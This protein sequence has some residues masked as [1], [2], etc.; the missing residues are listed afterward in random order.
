MEEIK[1]KAITLSD[2]LK[3]D[4]PQLDGTMGSLNELEKLIAALG[5]KLTTELM[6]KFGAY[7]GEVI[8]DEIPDADWVN[9]DNAKDI[10]G[11]LEYGKDIDLLLRHKNQCVF[12]LVKVTKFFHNGSTDSIAA[13]GPVAAIT[14]NGGVKK[15]KNNKL[16]DPSSFSESELVNIE[17]IKTFYNEPTYENLRHIHS[18]SYSSLSSKEI[19]WVLKN[20]S[21]EPTIFTQ[22]LEC[23]DV[24]K[25][26]AKYRPRQGAQ[27][28]MY[29]GIK[30]GALDLNKSIIHL[31]SLLTST[32]KAVKESAAWVLTRTYIDFKSM[33]EVKALFI[34]AD[35]PARKGAMDAFERHIS[36]ENWYKDNI[37]SEVKD[38]VALCNKSK[39][40]T[41][42]L[43]RSLSDYIEFIRLG[44][45]DKNKK[46][47]STSTVSLIN[48][49]NKEQFI[50]ALF[51]REIALLLKDNNLEVIRESLP[52]CK[53]FSFE[54]I[55]NQ[56]IQNLLVAIATSHKN[57]RIRE[58]TWSILVKHLREKRLSSNHIVTLLP[59]LATPDKFT[60]LNLCFFARYLFEQNLFKSEVEK[61]ANLGL[62]DN[63]YT[64]FCTREMKKILKHYC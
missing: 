2:E 29:K 45:A 58:D 3:K 20:L 34:K 63:K 53:F 46:I 64:N 55:K 38:Y 8:R 11:E 12:P 19:L 6:E 26:Y 7:F 32:N 42:K 62:K 59:H 30:V 17:H 31:K 36:D 33:S 27:E 1:N 24:G 41:N 57:G 60:D 9:Y 40:S 51:E 22:F 39:N 49:A 15:L 43:P 23:E 47:K 21:A 10:I 44:L 35:V 4:N 25:G 13:F 28:W 54:S 56:E 16:V 18:V 50:F 37:D 5:G 14:L 48:F 52:I 61:Y